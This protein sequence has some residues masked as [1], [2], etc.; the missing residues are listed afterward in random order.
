M[1][2]FNLKEFLGLSYYTSPADQF[3]ID[4]DHAHPRLSASQRF[5]AEKYARISEMRDRPS[6][7][8]QEKTSI[9]DKF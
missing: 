2:K 7:S 1:F 6:H 5:E 4:Y 9:W 8:Q 3:L